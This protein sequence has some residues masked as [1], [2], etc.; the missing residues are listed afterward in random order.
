VGKLDRDSIPVAVKPP[1]KAAGI[2]LDVFDGDD[3]ALIAE[4]LAAGRKMAQ[5]FRWLSEH[6]GDVSP[7]A[8][9]NH[10][11]G[12]CCCPAGVPLKAVRRG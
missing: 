1:C 2:M 10:L 4:E 3:L 11:V 5:V 6:L 9:N 7:S 8:F 12:R